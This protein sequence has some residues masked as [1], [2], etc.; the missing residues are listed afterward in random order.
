[1]AIAGPYSGTSSSLPNANPGS[2]L[3]PIGIDSV[4]AP[5]PAAGIAAHPAIPWWLWWNILSADAPMVAV[6]WAALLSRAAGYELRSVDAIILLLAVWVIYMSD[7][8]LDGWTAENHGAW[9]ERHL[10]CQR[11]RTILVSLLG[12]AGVAIFLLSTGYLISDEK[13]SGVKLGAVLVAYML[14]IHIGRGRWASLLP[15]ELVVGSLFAAGVTLP[16]W[17]R[18]TQLR[19]QTLAPWIL[20]ALLCSLNC[21]AIECWETRGFPDVSRK[22]QHPLVRWGSSRLGPIAGSLLVAALMAYAVALFQW[23][24]S[25]PDL[26]AVAFGALLLLLLN[27]AKDRLSPEALRVLADAALAAPALVALAIQR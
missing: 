10:F 18:F 26:I 23:G 11:H 8:L 1:M 9:Q 7:R 5:F 13:S 3:Q 25:R 2:S 6:L 14:S 15:K 21:L 12:I 4:V 22:G 17:S 24:A 20:F 27:N 19:L 16:L